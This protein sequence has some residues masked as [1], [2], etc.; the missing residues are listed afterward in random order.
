MGGVRHPREQWLLWITDQQS[1]GRRTAIVSARWPAHAVHRAETS[2]QL[3]YIPDVMQVLV[4][5]RAVHA[6]P[7]KQDEAKLITAPKPPQ[8]IEKGLV[9]PGLLAAMVVGKF[10]DHPPGYRLEDILARHGVDIRSSTIY[11]WFT[12]VAEAVRPLYELMKQRVLA[13]RSIHTDDTQVKLIDHSISGTRLARFWVR[14]SAIADVRP[15]D[16]SSFPLPLG[17]RVVHLT[18]G[19]SESA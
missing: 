6:C 15:A 12:G 1:S 9:S 3:D 10:G 4:H 5:R 8:P 7:Q 18:H 16:M 19:S 13:S 2:E 11:D 17:T 14:R